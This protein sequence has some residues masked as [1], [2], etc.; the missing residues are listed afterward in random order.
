MGN[1]HRHIYEEVSVKNLEN[2]LIKKQLEQQL[3]L[4]QTYM[5]ITAIFL[6]LNMPKPCFI[7]CN[8]SLDAI[9]KAV[10]MKRHGSIFPP[11]E[12]SLDT[13]WNLLKMSSLDIALQR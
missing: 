5:N 9:L 8:W 12:F 3:Y 6:D 11:R 13:Y 1:E 4:V 2:P 7:L 10:Y